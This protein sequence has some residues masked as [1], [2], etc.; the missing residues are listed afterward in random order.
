[1]TIQ[2]PTLPPPF[3]VMAKPIG[4]RC[5][6]ACRY[7]FYLEKERLYPGET[8]WAMPEAVLESFIRQTFEATDGPVVSFVWQGGEP[9]LLGVEY[10]RKILRLQERH[11]GGRTVENAL[12]TN[13]LLLDDAWC[14]LLAEAGF[15]VGLSV[16]GPREIHDHLRI[17][18]AGRPS[19]DRVAKGMSLLKKHGVE[20]NTLTA[21]HD[22]NVRHPL[23]V[24]RF[25]REAGSGFMQFIPIVERT[26]PA[27]A[28]AGVADWSVD[29]DRY[30]EFLC[31]LFDVWVRN[32]VGRTFVQLFDV[33]LEAWVGM[34]PSLCVFRETCGDAVALEHN[35]DLFSCDHYVY[36]EN[37][38]GN[39]LETPLET[40]VRSDRQRAFGEA[41][42]DRL[43]R[44]CRECDVRF[45]CN[46]ECPKHRIARAS[47]G[48]PG[49]NH[50]CEGYRRFFR[51]IDPYMRFM[52]SELREQRPPANVMAWTR[53]RDLQGQGKPKPGRNAPCPC[54]SGRK[55]KKCCGRS[56]V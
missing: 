19:F 17:D 37:R 11:A 30:G 23:E 7:C 27:P 21:V 14:A 33:A 32:D 46:G 4:P 48:E 16:D 6:L 24:Y 50:L 36:P 20:F 22:R 25:L 45:A 3:A 2:P 18:R 5:N 39:I 55:F 31:T 26:V 47:D 49:L 35:G 34:E 51:H 1:M 28:K 38:L 13:G 44:H 9:T 56:G 42:R 41:K 54:G 10:F 53:M 52:V 8:T 15:L 29:P 40:L 12:Q 43:P